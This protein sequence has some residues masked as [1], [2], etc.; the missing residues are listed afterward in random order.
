MSIEFTVPDRASPGHHITA[1]FEATETGALIQIGRP[2][3][4]RQVTLHIGPNL[5]K[6]LVTELDP[7]AA[8]RVRGYPATPTPG[9]MRAAIAIINQANPALMVTD[10]RDVR[11]LR[12]A[13]LIDGESGLLELALFA[14]SCA[15]SLQPQPGLAHL[16][17]L[18][19][20]ILGIEQEGC[21]G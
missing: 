11:A 1:R 2:G 10:A 21:Q 7:A 18:A 4:D 14:A 3:S 9:A 15:N 17:R 19:N 5:V 20:A 6:A 16:G 13:A 8:T 12:I